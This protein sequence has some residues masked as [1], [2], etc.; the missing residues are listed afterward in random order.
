MELLKILVYHTTANVEYNGRGV[1]MVS[2]FE[3]GAKL[4][5]NQAQQNA[6]APSYKYIYNQIHHANGR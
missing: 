5:K 6:T 2:T 3:I 1:G 4:Y